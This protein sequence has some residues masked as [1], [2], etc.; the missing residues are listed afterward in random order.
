GRPAWCL[1]RPACTASRPRT[2][3]SASCRVSMA[4]MAVRTPASADRC[5]S[6]TCMAPPGAIMTAP[7][8]ALADLGQAGAGSA[9]R[10]SPAV[11]AP[12]R[13]GLVDHDLRQLRQARLQAVPDPDREAFTGR[14]LQPLHL[15]EVVMA[16]L[17]VDRKS[18]V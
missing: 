16:Q 15:V 10:G 11:A 7:R 5:G 18:V 2:P 3:S 13:A 12:R 4:S 8:R 6:G 17:V 1:A 9:R 14:A